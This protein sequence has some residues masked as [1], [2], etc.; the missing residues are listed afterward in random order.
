M[1][2]E[3]TGAVVFDSSCDPFGT[4]PDG[5]LLFAMRPDG[6]GMRE[7]THTRGFVVEPDGTVHAELSGPFA[8]AARG[9]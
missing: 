9:H 5:D 3:E 6:S 8:Y 7:L 4:N 1:Q 2:D